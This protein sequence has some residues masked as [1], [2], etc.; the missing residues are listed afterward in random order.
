MGLAISRKLAILMGGSLSVESKLKEGSTF[1]LSLKDI[2]IAS[3]SHD[4]I[5]ENSIGDMSVIELDAAVILVVD[6]ITENRDL[7]KE[8]FYS[9]IKVIEASNG[10]EA[11]QAV[12]NNSV[13]LI[14]M[15]IRMPVMNGYTATRLIKEDN[16]IPII[17]LT[18]SIM[19][20]D[21]KKLEGSQFD[22][23]LRKPVS[24]NEL[25]KELSKFLR[26]QEPIL[27]T[28]EKENH[29]IWNLYKQII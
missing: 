10:Q 4:E 3:L 1:I 14:L 26:F 24:K 27:T 16:K 5:K 18:A 9:K 15:D 29:C 11:I 21:L 12:E 28:V 2:D 20:E 7:V 22:G 6:D 13:D 8:S 19:Q 17:A 25:I 23:Y